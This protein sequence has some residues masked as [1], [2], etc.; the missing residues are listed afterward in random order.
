MSFAA[1]D[2]RFIG[3]SSKVFDHHV[4]FKCSCPVKLC[5]INAFIFMFFIIF[6]K[7]RSKVSFQVFKIVKRE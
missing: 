7:R 3:Y 4:T 6:L 1:R 5:Q 2:F